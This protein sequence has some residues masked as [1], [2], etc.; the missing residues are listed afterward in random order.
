MYPALMVY[1]YRPRE[2]GGVFKDPPPPPKT[3][4]LQPKGEGFFGHFLKR[5]YN[6]RK[7]WGDLLLITKL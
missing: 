5:L 3:H 4:T 2:G 1:R 6:R 7:R